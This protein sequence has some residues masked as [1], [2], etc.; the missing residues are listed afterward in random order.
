MSHKA[1]TD[2]EKEWWAKRDKP[3]PPAQYRALLAELGVD[4]PAPKGAPAP[5]AKAKAKPQA[6][7]A[8]TEK[9]KAEAKAPKVE[10]DPAP[11]LD[12]GTAGVIVKDDG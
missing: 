3:M 12:D 11:F 4:V 2:A 7:R 5:K 10:K 9:R 6:A 8:R 1:M